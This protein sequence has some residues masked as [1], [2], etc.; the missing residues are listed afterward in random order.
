MSFF[1]LAGAG[2][3]DRMGITDILSLLGGL[4]LFLYGM[5]MTSSGLEAAAGAKM[6]TLLE[7]LT[8]N[9][10]MGVLVG[11]G[12]TAAIQSSSAT[13]VMVVGFVN[14]GMM[15]LNQAVWIIM[16]A[17]IGTT[18]TGMLIALDVGALAPLF[19]FVGVV[20]MVFVKDQKTQHI[21]QI[22]AGL[23]VLFI[24][25]DMMSAAMSPLRDSPA[26]V[27]LVSNFS[28]PMVGIGVGAG[29]TAVIQSSAAAV[30]IVQTLS[31]AGIIPL[32]SG[33]FVLFGTN[34]GTC[35]TAVLASMGT[36]RNA[37]RATIIHLL[38]NMIG[39]AIFTLLFLIFPIAQVIDGSVVLPGGLGSSL[40]AVLPKTAAG[41]IALIHTCFNIG[42]TLV[43]LPFGH[44]LAR[45]A[46]RILPDLPQQPED[47]GGMKLEYLTPLNP[48]GKEG[49]L[50]VSAIVIDQLR[51]ELS[52]MLSMAREN[53]AESFEAVSNSDTSML[54][55]VAEREEYID[56]LNRE[57]SRYVSK[58]ISI[59]TN[60]QGSTVVSSF[61]TISGN[62]ERI[63]DHADNL[64]GY[65][66]LLS[67]KHIAFSAAAQGEL[68]AMKSVSLEAIAALQSP[69]A[70]QPDW[71]MDVAQLEQKIDD[72]TADF[73]RS[74][75]ARM[76]SGVCNEEAC[77]LYSE[78][79]TD[80]ERMGDHVLNIAQELTK[81]Q[82]CL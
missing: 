56:F 43:L 71:L 8:A 67:E 79:L 61:F 32:A 20:L 42:T 19:A 16:G 48:N 76:R 52:R 36:S 57:I 73:R 13:T 35:I 12:I 4:A 11:A 78:L 46:V 21:G 63:G 38:F 55:E 60:E 37:K 53:V 77:I 62:I 31:N 49:G 58:L 82:T 15:T 66:R 29:F 7:R 10:F 74:Q 25:M 23:G 5:Q 54:P 1:L 44:A 28:N 69:Q 34:I 45:L 33:A 6:K 30:G 27:D 3:K 41:R 68:Q 39:T 59:E 18:I 64:A 70:G 81:A 65:S 51:H 17:N 80:F 22:L 75:L 40:A 2:R 24:G 9:R 26:F 14:A 72:M 47:N 50:G